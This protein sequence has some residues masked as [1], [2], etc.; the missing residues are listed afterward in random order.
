M[1]QIKTN[2]LRQRKKKD[3]KFIVSCRKVK[4]EKFYFNH[5]A[6]IRCPEKLIILNI[7][8]CNEKYYKRRNVEL[9]RK[10]T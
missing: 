5:F 3:E 6:S 1:K 4:F 2:F 10:K 7:S 9:M 8:S